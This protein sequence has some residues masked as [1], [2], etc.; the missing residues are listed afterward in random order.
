M[1]ASQ[2]LKELYLNYCATLFLFAVLFKPLM[3]FYLLCIPQFFDLSLLSILTSN[4]Q[5]DTVWE[6]PALRPNTCTPFFSFCKSLFLGWLYLYF[7]FLYVYVELYYLNSKVSSI[8]VCETACL[9]THAFLRYMHDSDCFKREC[10]T[11]FPQ[12]FPAG[13]RLLSFEQD[14]YFYSP[15]FFI[16]VPL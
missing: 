12:K 7:G 5:P 13:L 6:F 10:S 4:Q 9:V 11:L 1:Q 2:V 15:L 3:Y 14:M 16:F 8:N